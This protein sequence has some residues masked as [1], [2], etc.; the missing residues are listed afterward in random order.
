MSARKMSRDA[1]TVRAP[2]A[3]HDQ[4]A[5]LSWIAEEK[6]ARRSEEAASLSK[7]P[8]SS[9]TRQPPTKPALE[10]A[11]SRRGSSVW[12]SSR[13]KTAR[14][15]KMTER[16]WEM[17][18]APNTSGQYLYGSTLATHGVSH[19]VRAM[20]KAFTVLGEGGK[21]RG[22]DIVVRK[23][24]CSPQDTLPLVVDGGHKS[25]I[26]HRRPTV[27]SHTRWRRKFEIVDTVCIPSC[28]FSTYSTVL[29]SAIPAITVNQQA[30]RN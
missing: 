28:K 25:V 11:T 29:Y 26:R 5:G 14:K 10:S 19:W 12:S 13:A 1:L 24:L 7:C 18:H 9:Q 21:E 20:E 27:A 15:T 8:I 22:W 2:N 16:C 30:K 23:W 17:V 3:A 6:H 4:F